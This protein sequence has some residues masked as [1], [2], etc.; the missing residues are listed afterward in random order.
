MTNLAEY[1]EFLDN[2]RDDGAINMF[3]ARPFLAEAFDL[4]R[5]TSADILARWQRTFGKA[6]TPAERAALAA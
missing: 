3:G 5:K 4:D 1:F 6:K 2:L